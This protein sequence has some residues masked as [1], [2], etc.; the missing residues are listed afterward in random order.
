MF[1]LQEV[2]MLPKPEDGGFLIGTTNQLFLK[3]APMKADIVIDLDK[4]AID[5]PINAPEKGLN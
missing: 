1:A 2:D 3:F 5:P 4:G